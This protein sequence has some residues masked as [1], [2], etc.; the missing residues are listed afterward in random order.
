[1]KTYKLTYARV[2]I[3]ETFIEAED[4]EEA[5]TKAH[6]LENA[7]RLG[8]DDWTAKEDSQVSDIQDE[9][10]IWEVEEV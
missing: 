6:E 10:N 9:E 4:E 1:M 7:G 2:V 5:Y 8:L 3:L